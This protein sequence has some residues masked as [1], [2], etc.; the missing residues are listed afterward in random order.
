MQHCDESLID[1]LLSCGA[2]PNWPNPKMLVSMFSCK[3]NA[4][5]FLPQDYTSL[6]IAVMYDQNTIIE[7]LLEYKADPNKVHNNYY[8]FYI[9]HLLIILFK[10]VYIIVIHACIVKPL[11]TDTPNCR[12]LHNYNGQFTDLHSNT[13][14][15]KLNSM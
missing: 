2:D 4:Y 15:Y 14:Q 1:K 13:K 6:Q 10:L 12:H 8:S 11:L 3:I 7:K 9:I 5:V